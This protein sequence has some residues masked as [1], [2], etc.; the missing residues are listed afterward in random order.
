MA[1]G[2][3]ATAA[4]E[5]AM[6]STVRKCDA[7]RGCAKVRLHSPDVAPGV[8]PAVARRAVARPEKGIEILPQAIGRSSFAIDR[9]LQ[10]RPANQ[11][12]RGAREPR[13]VALFDLMGP[14][15]FV[16]EAPDLGVHRL[17]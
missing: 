1:G 12:L 11:R 5:C 10:E 3:C 15:R 8:S 14:D 2:R 6:G 4:A 17:R 9:P 7:N 16:E 13:G